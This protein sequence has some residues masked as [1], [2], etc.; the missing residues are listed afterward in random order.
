M[1]LAAGQGTRMKSERPKVLHEAV[2]RPLLDHVIRAALPLE[3]EGVVVVIGH[4]AERVRRRFGGHPV[5]F[6]EQREQLGTGHALLQ[7]QEA[8]S[9]LEGSIMVLNGDGPLLRTETLKALAT[10]QRQA[11]T[12]MTLLTCE[13][14]DPR[15]LGR[16]VRGT[17]GNVSKIVEAKDATP[18]ERSIHEVN[19]GIYIFSRDVFSMAKHLSNNNA[20][21]E[22]YITELVDIYLK[23]G[24]EVQAVL[25]EDETEV[26]GVN[27]RTHLALVDRILRD[28]VRERWL[29]AGVT[30]IA[31]EG[32][33]I[34]DAVELEPDVTLYPGV[35]LR[36]KTK[37]GRDAVVLPG[38]YLQ[39]CTVAPGTEVAPY[40]V[41]K[42]EKL[43]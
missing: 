32:V 2:G 31:P 13:V 36:G 10:K 40:T 38:A 24:R 28:R 37:V 16:V 20:A 14:S 11:A 6:V 30:M 1:I 42:G 27:T 4:E 25:A 43:E 21:G 9:E 33:F 12:G 18:E 41:A 26:L 7:T 17:N 35:W 8:L 19:T 34:D 3:P 15:G 29:A 39:D 23:A 5:D 22:Y